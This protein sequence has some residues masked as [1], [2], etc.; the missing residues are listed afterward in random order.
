MYKKEL[1]IFIPNAKEANSP[2][3]RHAYEAGEFQ[4]ASIVGSSIES[5]A[6][7]L[8][9]AYRVAYDRF[10]VTPRHIK[11]VKKRIE[12]YSRIHEGLEEMSTRILMEIDQR[13]EGVNVN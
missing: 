6:K 7:A 13:K 1:V 3:N 2:F 11:L 4:Q 9:D 8:E 12:R 10:E 5:P